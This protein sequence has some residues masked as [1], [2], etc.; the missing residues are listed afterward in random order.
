MSTE[1]ETRPDEFEPLDVE[2]VE[3]E[4]APPAGHDEDATTRASEADL[5]EQ[6]QEVELGDDDDAPDTA[7]DDR[8]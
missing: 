5:L 7:E 8:A 3:E 1:P 4:Y 6:E 2:P